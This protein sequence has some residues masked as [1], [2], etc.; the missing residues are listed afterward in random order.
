M[1]I[2]HITKNVF[3]WKVTLNQLENVNV[4]IDTDMV[5]QSDYSEALKIGFLVMVAAGWPYPEPMKPLK[6]VG[7]IKQGKRK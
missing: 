4:S 6:F 5:M 3:P 7:K 1:T 2:L